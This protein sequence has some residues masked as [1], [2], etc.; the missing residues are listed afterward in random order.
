MNTYNLPT[1][2][3]K[4]VLVNEVI[5]YLNPQP[6]KVYVD[7]TF[8]GGGHTRAILTH[9]PGCRVIAFDWDKT[10]IETHQ[11]EFE[12][13]FGDRI[14]FI[15]GNFAHIIRL[16][17]KEGITHVDGVL[18]DFGTSQ[19]QITHRAGFS[20]YND[21]PLDMRMSPAHQK[22]TAAHV[23][24]RAT[25]Q[26]LRE[27]FWRYSD[28]RYA[29]QIAYAI[30]KGR[31]T[32]PFTRTHQLAQLI[33]RVVPTDKKSKIHPATRVFQALRIYINGELDHINSFLHGAFQVVSVGG[34]IVCISF[35]SL[36]DRLVKT[37]FKEHLCHGVGKGVEV[38][39]P[40]A[41]F[42]SKEEIA[43]NPSS[44]SARLRAATICDYDG[45]D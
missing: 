18:A 35:H 11:E 17:K 14:Q 24:N 26:E 4:T 6:G 25:E 29:K 31:T 19:H 9:E 7:A 30:V 40:K 33:E 21:T 28:E 2:Y 32:K 15:W 12:K 36:E 44:R 42:A 43:L 5:E 23:V 16:L 8:G 20:V 22:I 41:V 1:D 34:P 37:F 38:L 27:I 39:T 3:H 10:A 45:S 13:L